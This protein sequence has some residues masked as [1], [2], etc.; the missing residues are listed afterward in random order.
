MKWKRTK[1]EE[2]CLNKCGL[3]SNFS[4]KTNFAYVALSDDGL[5]WTPDTAHFNL[6]VSKLQVLG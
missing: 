5:H 1:L 4:S 3:Y 2:M 6:S